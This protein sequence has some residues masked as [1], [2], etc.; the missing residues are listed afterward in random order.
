MSFAT[1]KDE[2]ASMHTCTH[3]NTIS[4]CLIFKTNKLLLFYLVNSVL[5]NIG[6]FPRDFQLNI[7]SQRM[8]YKLFS[9]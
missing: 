5:E 9:N 1:E 7:L 4:V 3:T 6:L 8:L 2:L